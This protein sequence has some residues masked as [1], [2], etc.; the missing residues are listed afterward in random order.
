MITMIKRLISTILCAVMAVMAVGCGN[1]ED[2]PIVE[3]DGTDVPVQTTTGANTSAEETTSAEESTSAE[4]PTTEIVTTA[5]PLHDIEKMPRSINGGAHDTSHVQ[6]IAIDTKREFM[7]FSFT[8]KLVKTDMQGNI[9]GTVENLVGHLGD[10]DFNDEDGRLYGSFEF[11]S[12]NTFYIAIFDVEQIDRIGINAQSSD[13]LSV[14]PLVDVYEDFTATVGGE[15]YRYGCSGIDGVAFGPSFG[16]P[17][18]PSKLMVAY[19]IFKDNGRKDNDYQVILEFDWRKFA[20]EERPFRIGNR[21]DTDGPSA[22]KRYF[23]YTGNTNYG[24]QNLEYDA[25]SG[26]WFMAVY[27]GEKPTFP[28]YYLYA[29]D[30]R[31]APAKGDLVGQPVPERGL[32]LPLLDMGLTHAQSGVRGWNFKYGNTGLIALDDGYFYISHN[33]KSGGKQ[34]CTAYLYRWVGGDTAFEMVS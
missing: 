10:L 20:A 3:P 17:S 21:P 9:V 18:S 15:R 8:T 5:P 33:S 6:G 27:L 2:F 29:V 32:I 14:V 4:E 11:K 26:Y 23:I 22:A 7:Y 31:S 19:G 24:V 1:L 28:N 30:G 34:T 13:L 16:D 12:I 25:S